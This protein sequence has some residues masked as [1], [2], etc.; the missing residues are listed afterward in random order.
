ML[1]PYWHRRMARCHRDDYLSRTVSVMTPSSARARWTLSVLTIP[2]RERYL[3]QL[4]ESL[5]ESR[6]PS[7]T[8]VDVVYN[9][10]TRE[11]PHDVERR[12]RKVGRGLTLN[13]HF[14]MQRPTIGCGRVQQLNHCKTPLMAFID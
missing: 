14:N 5:S 1:A 3:A 2:Q 12:L 10:D 11:R 6:L 7:G 13:V 4:L 9:W 8:V